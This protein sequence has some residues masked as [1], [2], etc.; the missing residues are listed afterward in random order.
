[1]N[2]WI[3]IFAGL[4]AVCELIGI[5]TV[6]SNYRKSSDFARDLSAKLQHIRENEPTYGDLTHVFQLTLGAIEE[7]LVPLKPNRWTYAGL[8]S[9]ALGAIA[10]LVAALL[11]LN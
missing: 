3:G 11:A 7:S 9:F 4:S 2:M 6:W 1:M 5:G 10:G 8:L